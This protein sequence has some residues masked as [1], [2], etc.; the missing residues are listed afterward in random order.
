MN[1]KRTWLLL[2]LPPFIIIV[3]L[4]GAL[5]F[6]AVRV[7]LVAAALAFLIATAIYYSVC[8]VQNKNCMKL[9][10]YLFSDPK[11]TRNDVPFDVTPDFGRRLASHIVLPTQKTEEKADYALYQKQINPHFLYNTLECIRSEALMSGNENIAGMAEHLARFFRYSIFGK[12]DI[13][14]VRDELENIRD[15]FF[16]QQY[17]FGDRCRLEI[18]T[19]DDEVLGAEIPKLTIQPIVENAIF[20]GLERKAKDGLVVVQIQHT[21]KD[22]I[23]VISDNGAGVDAATLQQLKLRISSIGVHNE[24]NHGIAL[25]NVNKRL[26]MHFGNEYGIDIHS[27]VG[28]G[29]DVEIRIPYILNK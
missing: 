13:L 23:I 1:K 27:V 6:P 19:E 20:H 16:I 15:Y 3:L 24:G 7:F 9:L 22:V 17:R 28:V 25:P 2:C 11:L 4:A 18:R 29:T 14:T 12:A 21:D 10:S 8:A 5:I 26:K